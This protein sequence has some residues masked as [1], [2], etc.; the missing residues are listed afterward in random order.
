MPRASRF[1]CGFPPP[2]LAGRQAVHERR[3]T[4]QHERARHAP[5]P[6]A[7]L[8]RLARCQRS[9]R[10]AEI[11]VGG[12]DD[13]RLDLEDE[14]VRKQLVGVLV[15]RRRIASGAA[16]DERRLGWHVAVAL[17]L[18][19]KVSALRALPGTWMADIEA[20]IDGADAALHAT[21]A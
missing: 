19:A 4:G 11:G 18:R 1:R 3:E 12:L 5:D 9:Q 21:G 8:R 16:I 15:R 2:P 6:V 7:P 10:R 17:L 14:G 20:S 13:E